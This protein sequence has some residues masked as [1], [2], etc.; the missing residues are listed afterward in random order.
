VASSSVYYYALNQNSLVSLPES[1]IQ[2]NRRSTIVLREVDVGPH[3]T[4]ARGLTVSNQRP[5]APQRG[6]VQT[7]VA[8]L[9][10]SG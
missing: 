3:G 4:D 1:K 5:W 9:S 7:D 6:P 2:P 10:Y 8:L